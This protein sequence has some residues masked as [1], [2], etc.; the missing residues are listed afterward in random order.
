[1]ENESIELIVAAIEHFGKDFVIAVLSDEEMAESLEKLIKAVNTFS[2]KDK[3]DIAD[4]L[5][6]NKGEINK[7]NP[8]GV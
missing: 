8:E 6:T 4:Y 7:V 3:L 1:M 2:S 5:S